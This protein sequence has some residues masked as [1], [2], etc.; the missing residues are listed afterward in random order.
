MKKITAGIL[1]FTLTI[2]LL[3]GAL[4]SD[5]AKAAPALYNPDIK[6]GVSTWDCV[7]F[8]NYYQD[9][10]NGIKKGPIKW[11]V[12]SVDGQDAFLMSDKILDYQ[13]YNLD[14]RYQDNLNKSWADSYIRTW[15]NETFINEA[16]TAEEQKAI[17]STKVKT[18]GSPI[19][20]IEGG[21]D[22]SDKVYLPSFEEVSDAAYGFPIDYT[23]KS[24]ARKAKIT[25]YAAWKE[26]ELL[27]DGHR[28]LADFLGYN[29]WW[30]RNPARK[31]HKM[32]INRSGKDG[33]DGRG[34]PSDYAHGVRP[35]L[36]IDLSKAN[37]LTDAA[38]I[39]CINSKREAT[40][41]SEVTDSSL[42]QTEQ[43][44]PPQ[45][46][47]N[48]NIQKAVKLSNVKITS[49]KNK[50]TDS[51]S[52]KWKKIAGAVGYQLQYS[53]NKRFKGKITKNTKNT[54]HLCRKLDKN[55]KYYFRIRAYRISDKKSKKKIYGSWSKTKKIT[56]NPK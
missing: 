47:T 49:L 15:L 50:K 9:D 19:S 46:D 40:V 41:Q 31:N 2:S 27:N 30:L 28:Q 38:G 3:S 34:Y 45:P 25:I 39:F 13:P 17:I 21:L 54:K 23:V 6:D 42:P 53:T 52:V 5:A 12:L 37:T 22:T 4:Q 48:E 16:F 51:V 36:H 20:G 43:P 56:V 18:S 11:R 44:L 24:K 1:A 14:I 8:G 10:I 29:M 32:Y 26:Y 55:K 35:V 7:W 33:A